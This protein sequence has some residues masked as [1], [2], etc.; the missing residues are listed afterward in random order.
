MKRLRPARLD[1]IEPGGLTT[2]PTP[3]R[4]DL[5]RARLVA[6]RGRA[7]DDGGVTR[8]R[9][10]TLG[11]IAG[12]LQSIAPFELLA[13]VLFPL[14]VVVFVGVSVRAWRV[15]AVGVPTAMLAAFA[16]TVV[17]AWL[18]P[19]KHEDRTRLTLPAECVDVET[20]LRASR[21]IWH[22]APPPVGPVC[23]DS[24]TPTLRTVRGTLASRGIAW[25]QFSCANGATILFGA[26]PRRAHV[27]LSVD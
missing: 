27:A 14:W 16:V 3:T 13:L 11:A 19:L 23:F 18:A 4:V 10:L 1:G 25:E 21:A 20:I 12:L 24:L 7:F 22:G 9:A 26:W 17:A 15:R 5:C 2:S 8:T 6:E